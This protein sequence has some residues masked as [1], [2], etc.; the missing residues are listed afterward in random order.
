MIKDIVCINTVGSDNIN[1]AFRSRQT[2]LII[3][4]CLSQVKGNIILSNLV[5]LP[6]THNKMPWGTFLIIKCYKFF[7]A[8]YWKI[9]HRQTVGLWK[10]ERPVYCFIYIPFPSLFKKLRTTPYKDLFCLKF[11]LCFRRTPLY[12]L[13]GTREM[14]VKY[15]Q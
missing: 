7:Q 15:C 9:W 11:F 6:K 10:I 5:R 13:G 2:R 1:F 8:R 4:K 3:Y 14:L 12:R